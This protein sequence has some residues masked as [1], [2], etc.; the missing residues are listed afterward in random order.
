MH[1]HI[2]RHASEGLGLQIL[3][4]WREASKIWPMDSSP[5]ITQARQLC[6]TWHKW[7]EDCKNWWPGKE[8]GCERK[9]K[10]PKFAFQDDSGV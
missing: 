9:M 4:R 10:D 6:A 1:C 3:E 5:D 2:A 7:Q 8:G